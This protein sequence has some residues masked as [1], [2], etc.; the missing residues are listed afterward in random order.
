MVFGSVFYTYI[1]L[2]S[3]IA[4]NSHIVIM[5]E[6]FNIYFIQNIDTQNSILVKK[7]YQTPLKNNCDEDFSIDCERQSVR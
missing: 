1:S 3:Y 2:Y 7:F 4:I 5:I 6:N